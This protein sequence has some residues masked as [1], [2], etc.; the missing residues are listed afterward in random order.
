MV[1]VISAG[2]ISCTISSQ[3]YTWWNKAVSYQNH[4]IARFINQTPQPLLISETSGINVGNIISLSYLLDTKV[5]LQLVVNP[6][7][8]KIP[9]GFSDV[10]FYYPA[11]EWQQE[12]EREYNAKIQLIDDSI[13]IPLWKLKKKESEDISLRVRILA[14]RNHNHFNIFK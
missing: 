13:R 14:T 6:N 3:A 5:K 8:P 2:V 9:D 12:I 11:P 1:V 4:Q 10:F 7:V